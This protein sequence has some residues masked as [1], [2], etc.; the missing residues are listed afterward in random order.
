[1]RQKRGI[2][3]FDGRPI[4]ALSTQ[5]IAATTW[6]RWSRHRT[7]AN[8]W[9]A[10][11][12]D[13]ASHLAL[14]DEWLQKQPNAAGPYAADGWLW[15]QAGDLPRAQGRLLQALERDPHDVQALTQL[16]QVYEA[17]H[18]PERAVVLYERALRQD[19]AQPDVAQRLEALRSQGVKPPRP[20]E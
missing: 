8:P 12:D 1:M 3:I 11:I 6:Q 5:T 17:L 2:F 13:V 4:G 20:D 10:G 15:F 9:R 18:R 19:P 7:T 16:A 14:V